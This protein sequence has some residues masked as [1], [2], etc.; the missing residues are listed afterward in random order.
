M[1]C[2]QRQESVRG[3]SVTDNPLQKVRQLT[4]ELTER[5][6]RLKFKNQTTAQIFEQ[7]TIGIAMVGSDGR[8]I[9]PNPEFCR[10]LGYSYDELTTMTY[11]DVTYDP[12]L[13][14]DNYLAERV[15]TG[16]ARYYY[17]KKRYIHKSG[18]VFPVLLIVSPYLDASGDFMCFLS[19]A[20]DLSEMHVDIKESGFGRPGK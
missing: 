8:W 18:K 17:M 16:D 3:R 19:Q 10:M 1:A 6:E 2:D 12:D 15:R 11:M 4:Q 13:E 9:D 5:D 14:Q 20:L 7:A